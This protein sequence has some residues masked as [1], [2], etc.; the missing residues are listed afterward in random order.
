MMFMM[1]LNVDSS[2]ATKSLSV[3]VLSCR[4]AFSGGGGSYMKQGGTLLKLAQC[5][6]ESK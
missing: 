1:G 6:K 3:A 5:H 2:Q 4:R